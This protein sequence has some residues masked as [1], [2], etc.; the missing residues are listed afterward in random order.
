ME[1]HQ[2]RYFISIVE[3]G[4]FSKAAKRCH[5]AQPSLSQQVIK[6]E[7]E[8]GY[9]LFDRLG[10]KVVLTEAG[11]ALLPRAK[12]I[13]QETIEVKTD[14]A[15]DRNINTGSLSVGLIATIAPY[16]L[17][18]S[19]KKFKSKYRDAEIKVYENLTENLID[20][21]IGFEID[22]AIMSLPIDNELIVYEQLFYDPLVLS[23]P[24]SFELSKSENVEIKNLENIPFIALDEQ[25]CL[26]EQ[27]KSICYEKQISPDVVCKTWNIS[28]ILNCVS[29][30]I[31]LSIVPLM[32]ALTNKSRQYTFKRLSEN[33]SRAVVSAFYKKRTKK[34]L[35]A[36]FEQIITEVYQTLSKKNSMSL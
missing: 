27:V 12:R 16:L 24:K 11:T 21:L 31:G 35:S 32:T 17:P 4:S 7:K 3:T 6:L 1:L 34:K 25:H 20:M 9:K 14:I 22:I 18:P 28:T 23:V 30:G 15:D 36:E 2:L 33:P 29:R 8:L 26:G 5:V 19:L 13:I 10:N